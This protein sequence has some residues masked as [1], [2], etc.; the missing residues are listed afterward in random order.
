MLP[1]CLF[2]GGNAIT[3]PLLSAFLQDL[4]MLHD[5]GDDDDDPEACLLARVHVRVRVHACACVCVCVCACMCVCMSMY[6][7]MYVCP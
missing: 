7:C 5:A 4:T 6:A 3:L 2:A 1:V